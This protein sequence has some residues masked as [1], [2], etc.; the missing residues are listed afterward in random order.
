MKFEVRHPI[1]F[2][3]NQMWELAEKSGLDVNS[4]YSYLMMTKFFNDR[5]FV[6][7]DDGQVIGFVTGFIL[8]DDVYFVWQIAIDP[9]YQGKGLSQKLLWNAVETLMDKHQIKFIQ[10]TVSPENNASMSLFKS[11]ASSYNTFFAVKEGFTENHFPDDKP[12]EKLIQVGP[13][14]IKY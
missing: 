6:I 13:L 9:D 3:S 11:I 2:E 10:A 12:E 4:S 7:K 5:C 8:K 1:L 14:D